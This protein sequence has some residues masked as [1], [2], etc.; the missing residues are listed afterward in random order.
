[1]V[2]SR[3]GVCRVPR[4]MREA[5]FSSAQTQGEAQQIYLCGYDNDSLDTIRDLHYI[6]YSNVYSKDFV[7][8]DAVQSVKSQPARAPIADTWAASNIIAGVANTSSSWLAH[9]IDAQFTMINSPGVHTENT[10][11]HHP[12]NMVDV[13]ILLHHD[14]D[15][16]SQDLLNR[17]SNLTGAKE[18]SVESGVVRIKVENRRSRRGKG[19][20]PRQRARAHGQRC[21]PPFGVPGRVDRPLCPCRHNQSIPGSG[22]NRLRGRHQIRHGQHDGAQAPLP[23]GSKSCIDEETEESFA[24]WIP[25]PIL[26][27][28]LRDNADKGPTFKVTMAYADLPGASLSIDL[29]LNVV[30]G[31]GKKKRHGNQGGQEFP[32]DSRGPYDYRNNVEQVTW[33]QVTGDSVQVVVKPYRLMLTNVP[34]A[35]AWKLF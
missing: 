24:V 14:I 11:H 30:S 7:V 15:Q 18:L 26:S 25:I 35:Y 3:L 32:A 17:I 27:S 28:S 12:D 4:D 2:Q 31:D 6:D 33:P 13:D 29:N 9:T 20:P 21:P 23:A 34:F 1:M 8:H 10:T 22:S 19:H 16:A 5:A